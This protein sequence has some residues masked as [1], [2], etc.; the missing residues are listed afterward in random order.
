MPKGGVGPG[1]EESPWPLPG[2]GGL[3]RYDGQKGRKGAPRG[4]ACPAGGRRRQPSIPPDPTLQTN[5]K[6]RHP[7]LRR[8]PQTQ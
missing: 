7:P 2:G 8:H 1:R 6:Q 5:L 3:S 4:E